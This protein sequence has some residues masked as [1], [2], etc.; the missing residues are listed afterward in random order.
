M[1]NKRRKITA[2]LGIIL[3][4]A[5]IVLLIRHMEMG[6]VMDALREARFQWTPV[7]A[8]SFLAGVVLRGIRWAYILR[9]V[10]DVGSLPAVN[11]TF[12]GLAVNFILPARMGELVRPVVLGT[13][14]G[15]SKATCLGALVIART[16][17]GLFL[18]FLLATMSSLLG[19]ER[20]TTGALVRLQY[21]AFAVFGGAFLCILIARF[22]Q[23]WLSA[24]VEKIASFLPEAIAAKLSEACQM[25]FESL[26]FLELKVNVLYVLLMTAGI[27]LL[28]GLAYYA[29]FFA[30][31]LDIHPSVAYLTLGAVALAALFPSAPA[32][33]GVFEGAAVLVLTG[34]GAMG[35]ELA[36]S[37]SIL[38]HSTQVISVLAIGFCISTYYKVSL[39]RGAS[40]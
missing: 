40:G 20:G 16:L 34:Y 4:G 28:E 3:S 8:C 33:V 12:I 32:Y 2:A 39:L 37:Y 19:L 17:D 36:F 9:P 18:V 26:E 5:I 23:R 29:G 14:T 38:L 7:M 11:A 15:T 35:K 30:F 21:V 6:R 24:V 13:R 22:K 1:E 10:R 31:G 25:L 27:W